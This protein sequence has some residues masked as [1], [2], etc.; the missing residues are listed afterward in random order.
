M[1]SNSL[2]SVYRETKNAR[3]AVQYVVQCLGSALSGGMVV[4]TV[5]CFPAIQS[6]LKMRGTLEVFPEV[7]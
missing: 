2:S 5:D 7:L 6:L 4:Y 1:N 3:L